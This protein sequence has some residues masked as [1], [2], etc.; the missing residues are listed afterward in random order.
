MKAQLDVYGA[1]HVASADLNKETESAL[2]TF[3][4]RVFHRQT[5]RGKNEYLYVSLVDVIGGKLAYGNVF[6]FLVMVM[7]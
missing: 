5:V 1:V 4:G 3:C 2:T 7:S 6:I